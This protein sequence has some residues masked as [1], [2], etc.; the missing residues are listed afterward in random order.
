MHIAEACLNN[1]TPY[2]FWCL[3][4]NYPDLVSRMHIQIR[5][6]GNFGL[7]CGVPWHIGTNCSLCLLCKEG[8]ED[9]TH[10]LLD[11]P[12]FKEN[13][14]SVWLNIKPELWRQ[15]RLMV[16]RFAISSVILTGIA[17]FC[18][19]SAILIKRFMS[20]VVGKIYKLHMNKLCELEARWLKDK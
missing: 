1:V 4:E 7:N 3:A 11:C 16:L 19:C 6:M 13:V 9:V 20:S 17:K 12:F 10:F 14:N 18:C 5:L 8:T 15:T 2:Q